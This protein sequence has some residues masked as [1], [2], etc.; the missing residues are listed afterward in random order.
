[1]SD[2]PRNP[3]PED[4]ADLGEIEEI[5]DAAEVD[6]NDDGSEDDAGRDD[7]ETDDEEGAPEEDEV[8]PPAARRG[9]GSQTIREQ[10]RR[11]QDAER[12]ASEA[13][14][15]VQNLEQQVQT[16]A[17]RFQQDPQAQARA[18]QAWLEQLEQ[19][20][21]AQAYQALQHRARQEFGGAL[22][23]LRIEQQEQ[24]DQAR[25]EA[26]CARSP[27][28]DAYRDRVEQYRQEQRR[29]GFVIGREEAFHLLYG[30]DLEAR[31]NKARPGQQRQAA[32]RVAGQQTRPTGARS[33]VQPGSRRPAPGS[34][35][36]DEALINAAIARGEQVF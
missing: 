4:E 8:A 9:G 31:A 20:P 1:M 14:R 32:R 30:R 23:Q 13:E 26:S 15:R 7:G 36:A 6:A 2:I 25:F 27:T 10:R 24:A 16:I 12:R 11:A 22:Q 28:R 21:P 33:T 17:T 3:A 34:L 5:E 19:M 35:E 18:E 29:L